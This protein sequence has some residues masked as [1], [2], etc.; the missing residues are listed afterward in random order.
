LP[1]IMVGFASGAYRLVLSIDKI[2]KT[3]YREK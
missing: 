2:K 1:C 3:D